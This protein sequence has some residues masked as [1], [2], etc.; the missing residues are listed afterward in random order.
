MAGE[1][2]VSDQK[3]RGQ[4]GQKGGKRGATNFWRD[5][6]PNFNHCVRTEK[7]FRPPANQLQYDR[8]RLNYDTTHIE[9]SPSDM[10]IYEPRHHSEV[11][12]G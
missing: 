11:T 8:L 7:H 6:P 12:V 2:R 9:S 10:N 4:I 3:R 1:M 5:L